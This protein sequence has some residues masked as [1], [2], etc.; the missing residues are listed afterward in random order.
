MLT[1]VYTRAHAVLKREKRFLTSTNLFDN[2]IP[3]NLRDAKRRDA[4][5]H[6]I[7]PSDIQ[8]PPCA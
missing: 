8:W 4:K 1:F 7:D 2:T 5:F 3:Y 6:R